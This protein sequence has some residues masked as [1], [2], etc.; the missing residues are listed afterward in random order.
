M[1]SIEQ[2]DQLVA[3]WIKQG[4][5]KD[6]II[7]NTSYAEEGMDYVWGATGQKCTVSQRNVFIKRQRSKGYDDE[8]AL[9]IKKCQ[10]L[11]GSKSSCD[12]CKFYPGGKCTMIHDCQGFVK[13]VCKRVG[14]SLSGGGA[15][16][17]WNTKANWDESGPISKMPEQVCCIFWT[18]KNKAGKTVKSHIGFYIKN[19]L[20]AHCSGSVKI[21]KL[22]KKCTDYALIKGLSG[23]VPVSHQTIKRG[24]RGP[25][26]VECQQD[27]IKL[28]YD[29]GPAGADGIFGKKTEAAVKAF[30]GASGLKQD[31]ICGADTWA[32][33]DK[34]V[35]EIE[36]SPEP[37]PEPEPAP[38]PEPTPEPEPVTRR[39]LRRGDTGEDVIVCQSRLVQ[40]DYDI[41]P[42]GI[43]GVYGKATIAAVKAFQG[44]SGLKQDG[45]C[46]PLTWSALDAAVLNAVAPR[47]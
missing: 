39:T 34:A 19:G 35:A 2:V 12:G 47:Q 1:N 5:P 3:E 22:S 8:A 30:Q 9:T 4:L 24:S 27:L 46:G 26:V 16:S 37:S 10:V 25:D 20:M 23:D 40:L 18:G 17:L 13:E 11:N 28:E 21:E 42:C 33:L 6:E 38:E 32:A 31:G 45:I 41:G 44:V 36:P 43:D 14:I 15:T 29:V 7:V